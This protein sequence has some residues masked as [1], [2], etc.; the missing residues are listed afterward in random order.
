MGPEPLGLKAVAT[1]VIFLVA[2]LA[3][4]KAGT[5]PSTRLGHVA[6]FVGDDIVSSFLY[7]VKPTKVQQATHETQRFF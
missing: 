3:D 2:Q 1:S 5:P 6:V 4:S 7:F